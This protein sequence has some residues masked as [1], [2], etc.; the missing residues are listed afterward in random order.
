MGEN[1]IVVQQEGKTTVVERQVNRRVVDYSA[2]YLTVEEVKQLKDACMKYNELA[3]NY[4]A[5][6][7]LM[8]NCGLRRSEVVNLKVQQV[9]FESG[10]VKLGFDTK[11]RLPRNIPFTDEV[12]RALK[13]VVGNRTDGYLLMHKSKGGSMRRYSTVAVSFII[14]KLGRDVGIKPKSTGLRHL[15]PH[16]L[17][18]TW[19]KLC[20]SA[21]IPEEQ[22]QIMG[23]WSDV[24]M[25]RK[26]YGI[27]T[28]DAISTSVKDKMR[29]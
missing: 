25:I 11:T 18:H 13:M 8:V 28:Y 19:T 1:Y 21:G 26:V 3:P 23:G 6:M 4:L 24:R 14:A 9:D 12:A 7:C 2:Y 10:M 5:M 16:L 22:V 17:R 27:P 20:K 15:N 29:W